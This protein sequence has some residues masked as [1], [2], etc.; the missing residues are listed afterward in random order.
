MSFL[1][2]IRNV[3]HNIDT[4]YVRFN[5][6]EFT[7]CDEITLLDTLSDL[8]RSFVRAYDEATGLDLPAC[9]RLPALRWQD[10]EWINLETKK[11]VKKRKIA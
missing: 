1:Y 8:S 5:L 3:T 6:T 10:Y 11:P 9:S 7:C 2:P 4:Q